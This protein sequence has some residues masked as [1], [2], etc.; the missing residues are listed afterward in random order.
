MYDN[1][2]PSVL[3]NNGPLV[4]KGNQLGMMETV[5]NQIQ[6]NQV[7]Y[8]VYFFLAGRRKA[9]LSCAGAWDWKGGAE[10]EG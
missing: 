6:R 10:E 1:V 3:G 2:H 5:G 7:K 4:E 9:C 8:T